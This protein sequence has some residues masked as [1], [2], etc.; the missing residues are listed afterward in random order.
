LETRLAALILAGRKQATVW[1]GALPNETAPGMRW[2]VI[3]NGRDVAVIETLSVERRKFQEIDDAFA[4]AEGEGD[5]SLTFW[6]A[7]HEKFFREEGHFT[8]EMEL[9]CERFRLVATLDPA[10]GR[11]AESHVAAEEREAADILN[12]SLKAIAGG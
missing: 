10:L 11:A 3:A 5:R 7:V 4:F 8:P 2:R 6:R 9:W 12:A 1:N